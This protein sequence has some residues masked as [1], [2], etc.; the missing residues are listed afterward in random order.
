MHVTASEVTR[1]SLT[2]A[3]QEVDGVMQPIPGEAI[4]S[5]MEVV[6]DNDPFD[7]C[8]EHPKVTVVHGNESWELGGV[9][10]AMAPH[11]KGSFVLCFSTAKYTNEPPQPPAPTP[12]S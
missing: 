1:P 9:R 8:G 11:G 3:E 5:A 7:L 10:I 6:A 4:W 12:S 2:I